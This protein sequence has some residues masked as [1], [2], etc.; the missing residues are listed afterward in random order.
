MIEFID[1]KGKKFI[2]EVKSDRY[3]I[4]EHPILKKKVE[5]QQQER[6][7][8]IRKHYWHKMRMVE[9]NGICY[10]VYS[11][12]TKVRDTDTELRAFIFFGKWSGEDGKN[13]H[14]LITND[15]RLNHKQAFFLYQQRWGIEEAF[16]ELKD[17]F[18]FDHYQVRHKEKIMRY[19][20]LCILVWTL[21]Y[22]IKTKR[23]PPQNRLYQSC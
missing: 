3:L 2:S 5:L 17:T 14:T 23:L 7:I 6:V 16:E 11:F 22:W 9:Y 12:K 4:F 18:Y 15:L 21:V 20:M 19:W 13:I 1:S 8:L 10:P